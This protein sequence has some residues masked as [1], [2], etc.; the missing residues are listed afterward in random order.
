MEIR[1]RDE[2]YILHELNY[3]NIERYSNKNYYFQDEVENF[4]NEQKEIP[5]IIQKFIE[6][7]LAR[8]N[9]FC[10]LTNNED[11]EFF[12][13]Y[14]NIGKDKLLVLFDKICYEKINVN[15]MIKIFTNYDVLLEQAVDEDD[16]DCLLDALI[17][18]PTS[19]YEKMKEWNCLKAEDF[20]YKPNGCETYKSNQI[21]I[22]FIEIPAEMQVSLL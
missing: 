14:N 9:D 8:V 6:S 16:V 15:R 5:I 7:Y 21:N 17:D 10:E 18:I 4:S 13:W 3:E 11:K 12:N 19:I 2:R 1:S 20:I 22:K